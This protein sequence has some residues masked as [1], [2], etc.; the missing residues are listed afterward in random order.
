MDL[1]ICVSITIRSE[2]FQMSG[3]ADGCVYPPGL[4]TM[5]AIR[6]RGP[7][8]PVDQLVFAIALV[9][10]DVELQFGRELAAVRSTSA[11]SRP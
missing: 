3:I 4:M 5:A 8:D 11:G 10:G 2:A 9:E 6:V 1:R 7:R